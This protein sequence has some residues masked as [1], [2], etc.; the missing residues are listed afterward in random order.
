[1]PTWYGYPTEAELAEKKAKEEAR[2]TAEFEASVK[3]G[4]VGRVVNDAEEQRKTREYRAKQAEIRKNQ[5]QA[6]KELEARRNAAK[7]FGL[8]QQ[9]EEPSSAALSN[10]K[11]PPS[12]LGSRDRDKVLAVRE[13]M[14]SAASYKGVLG[15]FKKSENPIEKTLAET[16]NVRHKM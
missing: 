7:E 11:K 13:K 9:L 4:T 6:N 3:D 5:E 12:Q 16:R 14:Q 8:L 1:M 15:L 10:A 2:K